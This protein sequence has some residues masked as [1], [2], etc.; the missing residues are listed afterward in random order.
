MLAA[1]LLHHSELAFLAAP[2]FQQNMK[3][4]EPSASRASVKGKV[5]RRLRSP[6][7]VAAISEYIFPLL[8]LPS[9]ISSIGSVRSVRP[10]TFASFRVLRNHSQQNVFVRVSFESH[11]DLLLHVSARRRFLTAEISWRN[12]LSKPEAAVIM[13]AKKVISAVNVARGCANYACAFITG[14]NTIPSAHN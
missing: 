10:I 11:R 9:A 14:V 7:R 3:D 5:D 1:A 12:F 6:Q 2:V 8:R 4:R 13:R